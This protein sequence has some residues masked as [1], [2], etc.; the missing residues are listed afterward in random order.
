MDFVDPGLAFLVPGKTEGYP[1]LPGDY[2]ILFVY[3]YH[4]YHELPNVNGSSLFS[5]F[6]IM[7]GV[8]PFVIAYLTA[9][10]VDPCFEAT[11]AFLG[12]LIGTGLIFIEQVIIP[13]TKR[14]QVGHDDVGADLQ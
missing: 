12:L 7:P 9:G 1:V 11:F 2:P 8:A 3:C 6:R 14:R 13:V 4:P 5:S 10:E